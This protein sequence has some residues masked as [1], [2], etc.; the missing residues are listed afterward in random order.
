MPPVGPPAMLHA[1]L[2][3]RRVSLRADFYFLVGAFSQ[4]RRVCACINRIVW[5]IPP[6][7]RCDISSDLPFSL[8]VRPSSLGR[9]YVVSSINKE[10]IYGFRVFEG[11][12][13]IYNKHKHTRGD[14]QTEH[15][16][17]HQNTE[18]PFDIAK[19]NTKHLP[20][21]ID[22]PLEPPTLHHS[23]ATTSSILGVL[24]CALT[25]CI[26]LFGFPCQ[27]PL[28][29]VDIHHCVFVLSVVVRVSKPGQLENHSSHRICVRCFMVL[30]II[31]TS[32]FTHGDHANNCLLF[33]L[34]FGGEHIWG[35][36]QIQI[37]V[38]R[39]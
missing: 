20:P 32:L 25:R 8:G 16:E 38:Q 14:S 33:I 7:I 3:D 17:D 18:A 9:Q 1:R 27:R 28:F 12:H 30:C 22:H 23:P 2:C 34:A 37:Q 29:W 11:E 13:T 35:C 15:S 21:P 26:E 19:H 31:H 4:I 10:I 6:I 39:F 24:L 36:V 5:Y